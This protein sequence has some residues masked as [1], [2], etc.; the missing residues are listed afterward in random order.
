LTFFG[1]MAAQIV[2]KLAPRRV[3]DAGCAWGL[4][5]EFL[6]RHG[7]DAWGIDISSYAISQVRDE[8]QP[9]CRV[10]SLTE[11]LGDRFD[12]ITCI[13]VL[14]HLS[15]SDARLAAQRIAEATDTIL[16]SSTT[17]DFNEPTHCNVQPVIAWLDMF[18]EL[19]FEPDILFD[20]SFVAPHAFLLRRSGKIVPAD[21]KLLFSEKIR[22]HGEL[23]RRDLGMARL[24][25][26]MVEVCS[27][28][29]WAMISR[30][31]RWLRGHQQ[32]NSLIWRTYEPV[33]S[34]LLGTAAGP[35]RGGA[36]TTEAAAYR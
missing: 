25:T 27:G 1:E 3:L 14:E 11:P 8:F 4:L 28:P 31:R 36:E 32:R 15:P 33:M 2:A 24:R 13:E 30:Y 35:A 22:L 23:N 18:S 34:W 16:F 6:R 9:F 20:A 7:V 12:L 10:A 26:E 17:D 21:V 29:A 5:V 19:G